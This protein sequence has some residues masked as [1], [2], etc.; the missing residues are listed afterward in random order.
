MFKLVGDDVFELD[1]LRCVLRVCILTYHYSNLL[2]HLIHLLLQ[3]LNFHNDSFYIKNDSFCA[4]VLREENWSSSVSL[5]KIVFIWNPTIISSFFLL[6]TIFASIKVDPAPGFKYKYSLFVDGK[7]LDQFKQ[8]QAKALR[9]WE[10]TI[11]E[12]YYRVV[13]GRKQLLV[14]WFKRDFFY[15]PNNFYCKSLSFDKKNFFSIFQLSPLFVLLHPNPI[16]KDTL[17]VY[18]NG[19]LREEEV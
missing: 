8:R 2:F 1:D 4:H 14:A 9:I 18:L 6:L 19:T 5:I 15:F 7:P 17:N 12:T 3:R 10:T 11:N 13:L 16:E